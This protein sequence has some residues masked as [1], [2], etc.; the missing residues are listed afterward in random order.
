MR[1]SWHRRGAGKGGRIVERVEDI[2]RHE[3]GSY[4]STVLVS[5]TARLSRSRHLRRHLRRHHHQH[6]DSITVK[7]IP[8]DP[9]TSGR[10][11]SCSHTC[12]G[13]VSSVC[14]DVSAPREIAFKLSLAPLSPPEPAIACSSCEVAEPPALPRD[15]VAGL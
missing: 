11:P 12:C 3:T 15:A 9:N 5:V 2:D 1:H 10:E 6:K 14:W 7:F 8:D 13:V 4:S